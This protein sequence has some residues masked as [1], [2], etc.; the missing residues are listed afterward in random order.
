MIEV[1]GLSRYPLTGAHAEELRSATVLPGGILGD[2]MLV[3]Y[4]P[5]V[6]AGE[7]NRVGQKQQ[8]K[9]SQIDAYFIDSGSADKW[10]YIGVPDDEEGT[11]M[12]FWGGDPDCIVN[13]FGTDTPCIRQ[14]AGNSAYITNFL[15]APNLWLAQ[16]TMEWA[17]GRGIRPRDRKVRPIHIVS[18]AS[19][20]A[21]RERAGATQFGSDRFRANI[22][23]DGD[24][25]PFEENQWVGKC[26][27][28]GGAV[29]EVVKPTPRCPVPGFDQET[30]QN[31]KDI[32]KLYRGLEKDPSN[33]PVFG[34]YAVPTEEVETSTISVGDELFFS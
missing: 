3:L 1:R 23:L 15:G 32:P 17:R 24:L 27:Q 29:L 20:R 25:E 12:T 18:E 8:P 6:P 13:E 14:S 30:G 19:V 31:M 11:E 10:F 21:L 9:L 16:K 22:V 2:R 26:I 4:D 5:E 7:K 28:I 34:V 33:T